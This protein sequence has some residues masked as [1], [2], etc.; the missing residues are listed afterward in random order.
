MLSYLDKEIFFF[1]FS[2]SSTLFS[3]CDVWLL[4]LCRECAVIILTLKHCFRWE[5]TLEAY[6]K[7]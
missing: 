6:L 2:L 4:V 3:W 5:E 7:T 1:F